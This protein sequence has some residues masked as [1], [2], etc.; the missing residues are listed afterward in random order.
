MWLNTR[1]DS[2]ACTRPEINP[3]AFIDNHLGIATDANFVAMLGPANQAAWGRQTECRAK[4]TQKAKK[5]A[6]GPTL[7]A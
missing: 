5:T 4:P 3:K 7:F 2:R 6:L 1:R